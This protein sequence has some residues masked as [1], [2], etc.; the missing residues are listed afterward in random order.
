MARKSRDIKTRNQNT[1]LRQLC[2]DT[3]QWPLATLVTVYPDTSARP[4]HHAASP[5]LTITR[6]ACLAPW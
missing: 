4:T 1:D 5:T 2:G 3:R 6:S